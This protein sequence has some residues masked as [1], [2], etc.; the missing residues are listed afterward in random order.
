MTIR[1]YPRP[2]NN[3]RWKQFEEPLFGRIIMSLIALTIII[4]A[5]VYW[6]FHRYQVIELLGYRGEN[7][8]QIIHKVERLLRV[9]L[10]SNVVFLFKGIIR[11]SDGRQGSAQKQLNLALNVVIT[12]F[13]LLAVLFAVLDYIYSNTIVAI[14]LVLSL[15][16]L[17][18]CLRM[19]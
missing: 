11:P 5:F 6:R 13:T 15:M 18:R 17:M 1:V 2:T 9:L 10:G 3:P 8:G 12:F 19:I 4:P 16:T 7:G 14:V